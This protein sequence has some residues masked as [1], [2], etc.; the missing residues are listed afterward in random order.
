MNDEVTGTFNLFA[1]SREALDW[2]TTHRAAKMNIKDYDSSISK[3]KLY[4]AWYEKIPV[5]F[6][7]YAPNPKYMEDFEIRYHV[8][9]G[10][11]GISGFTLDLQQTLGLGQWQYQ[12]I[13]AEKLKNLDMVYNDVYYKAVGGSVII[14]GPCLLFDRDTGRIET[15]DF[16]VF[17]YTDL[18][19]NRTNPLLSHEVIS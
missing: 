1:F 9:E 4:K 18:I 14:Q 13:W 3:L 11:S 2:G 6:V 15:I 12:C 10:I 8:E 5:N 7:F 17:D 16:S 19:A